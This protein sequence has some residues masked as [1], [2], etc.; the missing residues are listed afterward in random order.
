MK[1]LAHELS[2]GS[3]ATVYRLDH[4]DDLTLVSEGGNKRHNE[5]L[6]QQLNAERAAAQ[7]VYVAPEDRK[8]IPG[9]YSDEDAT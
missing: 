4:S 8:I 1:Y 6:A 2:P 3:W 7:P 9:F 5:Q